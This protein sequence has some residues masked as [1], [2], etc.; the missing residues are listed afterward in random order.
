[1]TTPDEAVNIYW[2]RRGLLL[3]L[4][5]LRREEDQLSHVSGEAKASSAVQCELDEW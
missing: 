1:M 2:Q 4:V 3:E 5:R